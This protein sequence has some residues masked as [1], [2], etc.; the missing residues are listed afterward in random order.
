MHVKKVVQVLN[1]F[2]SFMIPFQTCKV[3]NVLAMML[4]LHYK[5]LGLSFNMLARRGLFEL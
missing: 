5:G 2:I 1:V 4:N 3:H